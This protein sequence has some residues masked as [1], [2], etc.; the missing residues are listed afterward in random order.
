MFSLNELMPTSLTTLFSAYASITAFVMLVKSMVNELIPPELRSYLFSFFNDYFFTP[1]SSQLTLIIE[2]KCGLSNNQIYEAATTYLRTKTSD[3]TRLKVSKTARQK[4][5]AIDIVMGEEVIDSFDENIKLKWKFC[6][7]K[8]ENGYDGRQFFELSF[9]KKFKEVVLESYLPYVIA[10][11]EAIKEKEKVI[12]LYSR[13]CGHDDE[14]Y[15]EWGSINLEHP[16][17]FEKLAM[18]PEVKKTIKDDL[19][20]FVRRKEY[21][22]KVGKAWKR[23]YLLYGPPGTGKSS[24][25]AAMANY[26]KFNIYDLNLSDIYSDSQLRRILLSTSN[27]SILII[28]DIDCGAELQDREQED[29]NSSTKVSFL[30]SHKI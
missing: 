1:P 30:Y 16:T 17:T 18:D 24:L 23:G 12:K 15:S 27:R 20:R 13:D 2:E 29:K 10:S 28:E 22:K 7:E 8:G 14:D 5:S 3:S 19:D 11:S 26:L 9:D 6:A 25:I 4:K 21:Y